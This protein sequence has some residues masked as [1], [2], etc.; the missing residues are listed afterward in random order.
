MLNGK[1]KEYMDR[2]GKEEIKHALFVDNMIIYVQ[3]T[4]S[5]D[6]QLNLIREFSKF[7]R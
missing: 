2:I 1:L 5:I 6:K 3:K 4:E 7:A